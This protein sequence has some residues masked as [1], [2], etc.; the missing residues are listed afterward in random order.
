M[1]TAGEVLLAL[2][3]VAEAA[4]A[5]VEDRRVVELESFLVVTVELAPALAETAA[6]TEA[7]VATGAT[8][9]ALLALTADET[10]DTET[11]TLL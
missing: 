8:V 2:V 10:A 11:A 4:P 9:T 3:A 7:W 6:E 1:E 5:T